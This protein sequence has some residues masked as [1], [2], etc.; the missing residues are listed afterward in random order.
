M[1]QLTERTEIA[2]AINLN[3]Y[4]VIRIDLA[5]RDDYG[6]RGT[7]VRIDNGTFKSG[8]PYYIR[9][10]IRSYNDENCL[11]THSGSIWLSEKI[12]YDDYMEMTDYANAPL[13]KPNQEILIVPYNSERKEAYSPI[14][15][16]TGD[17]VYPYCSTPLT[18]E[19]VELCV[20]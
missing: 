10:E 1:K 12:T 16:K 8:E 15:I 13:I 20:K 5:D 3:K 17:R 9:A 7:K 19:K 14:V 2:E 4:P 18:L 6:I 11:T